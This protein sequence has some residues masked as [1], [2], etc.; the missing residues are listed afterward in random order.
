MVDLIWK[1]FYK[2]IGISRFEDV[3][4]FTNWGAKNGSRVFNPRRVV[5]KKIRIV[6]RA[7][8][9]ANFSF[10]TFP[11]L[12]PNAPSVTNIADP[13]KPKNTTPPH[14]SP[15]QTDSKPSNPTPISEFPEH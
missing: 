7:I 8:L 15:A 6:T 14:N 13:R 11:S 5:N 9:L 10:P 1:K 2:N 4:F 12:P 3:E